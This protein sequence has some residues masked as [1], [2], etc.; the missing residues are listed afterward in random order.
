MCVSITKIEHCKTYD[1]ETNT[2]YTSLSHKCTECE[3]GYYVSEYG[4]SCK[5]RDPAVEF[6]YVFENDSL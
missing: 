3:S 5:V 2:R 4:F 6:C 1:Y